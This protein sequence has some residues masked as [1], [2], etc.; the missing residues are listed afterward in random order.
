MVADDVVSMLRSR[1]EVISPKT[2]KPS[3]VVFWMDQKGEFEDSIDQID[4]DDTEILKWNGHNSFLIKYEVE[5]K[6]MDSRFLI[7]VPGGMPSDEENILADMLHY[8]KPFF[9]A[10]KMS[11]FAME[12]GISERN[13]D[14]LRSHE[15]F[16]NSK[17]RRNRLLTKGMDPQDPK[18]IMA[19][20][21]AVALGSSS[22][23]TT[24]ILTSV[25]R[26]FLESPGEGK[27]DEIDFK[28]EKYGLSEEFW[29]IMDKEFGYKG[30]SLT[31]LI[32]SLLITA[33][34]Q[35]TVVSESP[36]LSKYILSNGIHASSV[37]SR[38]INDPDMTEGM[39]DIIDWMTS[40]MDLRSTFSAFTNLELS[41]V[42]VFPCADEVIVGNMI[43]QLCSTHAPLDDSS[44]SVINKRIAINHDESVKMQYEVVS[45]ASD[46]LLL[47][48]RFKSED[49]SSMAPSEILDRYV[50]E[51]SVIDTDYRHFIASSD[52][53]TSMDISEII[54]LVE[55]T[56]TNVFLGPVIKGLCSKISSYSDMPGPAQTGFCDRYIDTGR[57]TV[58]IISDAFRYECA[59]ELYERFGKTSRIRDRKLEH[60]ISTVPSI[61][62][63]GM[64]ALL[65]NDGLEITHDG[66]YAVLIDGMSTES[67]FR[68][69]VLK[70]R[71]SDSIALTYSDFKRSGARDR[72][73][74][75]HL[76]YI[77]HDVVDAIGDDAKT[78]DKVFKACKDAM[79]E[80]SE[81][82]RVVTN[83]NYTRFIITADH[84]FLYRRG[85]VAEF[86]KID[87][88]GGS[89]LGRRYSLSD[90]SYG[91]ERTI[92]FSLDYLDGSNEG[93]YVS[94]PDSI[95][96]F[97]K[98]GGG[99]NFVHGGIS[100]QEIVVPV[101]TLNTV[102]GSVS[103]KYV[104]LKSSGKQTIK[105]RKPSILLLQENVVSDEYREAEYEVWLEDVSGNPL[106]VKNII[107]ADRTDSN[108]LMHRVVF[109][110][111]LTCKQVILNI[112]NRTNTDEDVK[113]IGYKVNVL[114]NDFI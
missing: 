87:P 80:I 62:K 20:M 64:A 42:K 2:G 15:V 55:D 46:L 112:R 24:D 108:D 85:D 95:G 38:I 96:I 90:Q 16:F 81:M 31:G 17:E 71:Y 111:E 26:S 43:G 23:D 91:L 13:V 94:T 84:G 75:K 45:S 97:R 78:E 44:I 48:N 110:V 98:Q 102:K 86:D 34:T 33:G 4:L 53:I 99:M 89:Q 10:D 76:I 35:S 70:S 82:V 47:C 105:Q 66:K 27:A 113:K 52:T 67:G 7:Y 59:A 41:D 68:E 60:M 3:R 57:N 8:S 77:Y 72:C 58:V 100:P 114:V 79:D 25:M 92:E 63:F 88:I 65:P 106:S 83:W 30:D 32:C 51:W 50:K 21:I 29:M 28:L 104:G 39:G 9:S 5:F 12:L 49:I 93:M 11:C 69:T 101:L 61:T 74:G 56:Y 19:S 73:K 107:R 40:R 22:L 6:S 54:K 1:F 103:E 36:K 109:D 14:V 18:S 37:V